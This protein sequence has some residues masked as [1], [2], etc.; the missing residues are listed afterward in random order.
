MQVNKAIYTKQGTLQFDGELDGQ[1]LDKVI[2]VGLTVLVQMGVLKP[3][4]A[5]K[6]TIIGA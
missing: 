4:E 6:S 2:E 3:K 1:E 5:P